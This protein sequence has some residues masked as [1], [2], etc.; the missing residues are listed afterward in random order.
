METSLSSRF[1]TVAGVL[2]IAFGWLFFWAFIDKLWGLGFA[3]AAEKGWLDGGN[4]TLG[5]LK[6]GSKGPFQSFYQSIAGDP[7]TNWLFMLGLLGIGGALLCGVAIRF[8]SICAIAMMLLMYTVVLPTTNNPILDDH[9]I[10]AL[11]FGLMAVQPA[12][13]GK[14][15]LYRQWTALPIVKRLPFLQ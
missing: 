5:F 1:T 13:F 2:R 10:Y 4:P 7:L 9:I 14:L 3:T 8:A 12:L 11:V 15:S 6:M